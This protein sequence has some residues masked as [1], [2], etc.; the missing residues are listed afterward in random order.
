[1]PLYAYFQLIKQ[2]KSFTRIFFAAFCFSIT[3]KIDNDESAV[4]AVGDQISNSTTSYGYFN[5]FH[6]YRSSAF[7]HS[8]QTWSSAF[9]PFWIYASIF[10]LLAISSIV[11]FVIQTCKFCQASLFGSYTVYQNGRN[12]FFQ[13]RFGDKGEE[14][15]DNPTYVR[16]RLKTNCKIHLL[17]PSHM[18]NLVLL[19][20]QC[21]HP[22]GSSSLCA[23]VSSL[24]SIS[25]TSLESGSILTICQALASLQT[26]RVS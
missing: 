7:V 3:N 9:W 8:G 24:A 6:V 14:P 11:L 19:F 25:S 2:M 1:M 16:L 23:M 20:L 12:S 17:P 18:I 21:I 15:F 22:F 4:A 5:L 26:T 13:R 10:I